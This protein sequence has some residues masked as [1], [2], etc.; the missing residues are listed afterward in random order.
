MIFLMVQIYYQTKTMKTF[1][2]KYNIRKTI[3]FK[4]FVITT[5]RKTKGIFFLANEINC[6]FRI[7]CYCFLIKIMRIHFLIVRT[8][9]RTRR[10][11]V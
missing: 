1:F 4:K 6:Q 9:T 5:K 3:L 2:R 7:H 11:I 8:D 10:W